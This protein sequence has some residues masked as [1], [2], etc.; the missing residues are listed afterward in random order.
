[1]WLIGVRAE[2]RHH[3]GLHQDF[4]RGANAMTAMMVTVSFSAARGR[5]PRIVSRQ[6]RPESARDGA[7]QHHHRAMM[8]LIAVLCV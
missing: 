6:A 7:Q 1:M 5:G 2:E 3:H 4:E 8:A